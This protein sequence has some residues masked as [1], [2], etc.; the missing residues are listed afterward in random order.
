VEALKPYAI[1]AKIKASI[2]K[3]CCKLERAENIILYAKAEADNKAKAETEKKA[4]KV[5]ENKKYRDK[6]K[7]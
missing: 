5:W 4:R 6:K 7:A 2:V 3:E 1:H